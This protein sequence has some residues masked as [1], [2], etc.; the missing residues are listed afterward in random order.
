MVPKR[1]TRGVK[2]GQSCGCVGVWR[3]AHW[4][5]TLVEGPFLGLCGHCIPQLSAVNRLTQ[6]TNFVPMSSP[7][8]KPGMSSSHKA[9][10]A[11]GRAE[12]K[13]IRE[14]L[15]IVEATKPRRGRKRTPESINRRLKAI[16]S[17]MEM[18]DALTKV[19]LVQERL[20]LQRELSS[21]KNKAQVAEAE[22]RFI[23]VAKKFSVRNEI[24]YDAW[25]EIGVSPTVLKRAGIDVDV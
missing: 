25:R 17:E 14:Y 7:K 13:V 21:M 6:L 20:N 16:T 2:L 4:D 3:C 11:N 8:K 9:A 23:K 15:E 24:T 18:C 12:G 22:S 5:N 19:R 1:G 10:L